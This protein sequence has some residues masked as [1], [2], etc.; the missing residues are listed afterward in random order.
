VEYDELLHGARR[1]GLLYG[2]SAFAYKFASA[3]AI[4]LVGAIL[5]LVGYIP[6]QAQTPEAVLGIKLTIALA[7]AILLVLSIWSSFK[8]PLTP[9]KHREILL[10]LSRRREA[11]AQ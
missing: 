8:Y 4:F 3:F 5:D 9:D 11:V 2:G 1:E 10:E 6:N 7:P